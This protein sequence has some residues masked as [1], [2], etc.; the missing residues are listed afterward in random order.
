MLLPT[1]P[2]SSLPITTQV[3]RDHV[4][5]LS[6]SIPQSASASHVDAA[7]IR[8]E[9]ANGSATSIVTLSGLVGTLRG[10]VIV[11]D[12]DIANIQ[13]HCRFR[14]HTADRLIPLRRHPRP[15]HSDSYSIGIT[16]HHSAQRG[17]ALPIV[18]LV[19]GNDAASFPT[20]QQVHDTCWWA[21]DERPAQ[22]LGREA[23]PYQPVYVA[24]RRLSSRF[25][26]SRFITSSTVRLY[27]LLALQSI[28]WYP[29]P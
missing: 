8:S 13:F 27:P 4:A 7:S 28:V 9:G 19:D 22:T 21:R 6:S 18:Y 10:C 20:Y 29:Q 1:T 25:A 16:P 23:R 12:M 2:V 15:S 5:F 3:L 24:L 11:V 14:V 26:R 17:P